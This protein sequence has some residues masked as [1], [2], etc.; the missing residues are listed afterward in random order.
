MRLPSLSILE[1]KIKKKKKIVPLLTSPSLPPP[2][3]QGAVL[4]S[5]QYRRTP[6]FSPFPFLS[7]SL[8]AI[9]ENVII[10]LPPL[11][12]SFFLCRDSR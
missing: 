11:I 5:S 3:F 1:K 8:L 12:S 2:R 10:G 7:I 9:D 4:M 6:S